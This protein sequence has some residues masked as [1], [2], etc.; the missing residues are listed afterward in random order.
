MDTQPLNGLVM[1]VQLAKTSFSTERKF[2]KER[3]FAQ[4]HKPMGDRPGTQTQIHL[5]PD[6]TPTPI[7]QKGRRQ[8][9]WEENLAQLGVASRQRQGSWAEDGPFALADLP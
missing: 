6:C 9:T 8:L 3:G 5:R 1:A 2:R 4:C 7:P